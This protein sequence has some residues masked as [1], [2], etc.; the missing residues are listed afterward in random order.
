MD[1]VRVT[2]QRPEDILPLEVWG[3]I[4]DHL[5]SPSDLINCSQT[6]KG[7]AK[8]LELRKTTF[9]MPQVFPLLYAY[10]GPTTKTNEEDESEDNHDLIGFINYQEKEKQ[11]EYA[12]LNTVLQMRL[13][14]HSWKESVDTFYQDHDAIN[15]L[16]FLKHVEDD[17]IPLRPYTFG[18]AN[19]TK[20]E[21]WVSKNFSPDSNPFITRCVVYEDYISPLER[22]TLYG[23]EPGAP[24]L[25]ELQVLQRQLRTSFKTLLESFGSQIWTIQLFFITT[26]SSIIELYRLVRSYLILMPNLKAIDIFGP[27]VELEEP[28]TSFK[29]FLRNEPM[30]ELAQLK[31]LFVSPVTFPISIGILSQ[32]PTLRKLSVDTNKQEVV[33]LNS[34][35]GIELP[36]LEQLSVAP[37]SKVDLSQVQNLV[38]QNLKG[39]R[40][41]VEGKQLKDVFGAVSASSCSSSLEHFILE[42]WNAHVHIRNDMELEQPEWHLEQL[43]HQLEL[44]VEQRLEQPERQLEQPEQQL[45][46]HKL[47]KIELVIHIPFVLE[48]LD[49]LLGCPDLQEIDLVIKISRKEYSTS[50]SVIQFK[51][52]IASMQDSNIWQLLPMLKRLEIK[53]TVIEGVVRG[54]RTVFP[55]KT[56]V[57]TRAQS[58]QEVVPLN[59]IGDIELPELEQLSVAPVSKVDLSQVPNLVWQNLKGLL[60]TVEGKQLKDVFGAVSASSF[61]S[62]LEH[63]ILVVWNSDVHIEN[64]MELEQP[65]LQLEELPAEQRLEHLERVWQQLEQPELQLEPPEQ[66]LQLEQP[67]QQMELPKLKKF[68]LEIS[69][70]CELETIDFLLGCPDLQEIHLDIKISS[71]KVNTSNSVIQFK[72]CIA[73]MQDSN[74]WQ[75]LPMLKRLEIRTT[76]I[77]GVVRGGRRV[78]PE[79]TYTFTR[80]QNGKITSS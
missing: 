30:P 72:S 55:E 41:T 53:T 62:S 61:S 21:S 25:E 57:F 76:E 43:E 77:E 50:N 47:K 36:E 80:G 71:K 66:Q 42:V 7:W 46:L 70:P 58:D 20:L 31:I 29:E 38:W 33:P 63:F 51:D 34:I 13:V 32:N 23:G 73:S 67:E 44:P 3:L 8:V 12:K 27:S 60:L 5:R 64:D 39:L 11:N 16:G 69:I 18:I 28:G 49:F 48:T 2:P 22:F 15:D 19:V 6:C 37:D 24:E 54:G 9:L 74:I 79:I 52:C 45:E 59:S 17:E 65:E 56:Y 35:R 78:F 68:H 14:S 40:L 1:L 4:L 26:D 75:L 10:L